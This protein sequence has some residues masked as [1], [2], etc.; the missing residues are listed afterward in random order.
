LREGY[1]GVYVRP[2]LLNGGA[3]YISNF[4]IVKVLP[5]QVN[6]IGRTE[7]TREPGEARPTIRCFSADDSGSRPQSII[8]KQFL[9]EDLP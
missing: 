1:G 9:N 6:K 4:P 3:L 5:N 2:F 7:L 8:I